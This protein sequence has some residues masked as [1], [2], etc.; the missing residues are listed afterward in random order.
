MIRLLGAAMIFGGCGSFGFAMAA[1]HRREERELVELLSAL[2]YMSCEL[3]FRQR[4]LPSL[5]RGA[6]QNRGEAVMAF[7]LSLAQ[8]LE[9]QAAP[10]VAGCMA[11]AL[12]ESD[13]PES[14]DRVLRNL[15]SSLGCFDLPGQLRGIE[16]ALKAGER[17]LHRVRDG[18]SQR[19][20]SYQT[21]GLCAGAALAIL[22]L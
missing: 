1:A 2:E 11:K 20:R 10:E 4:D 6:A 14:V 5:C 19:R 15:G 18:A 8:A 12:E 7:F 3:S 17:E 22:F 21:L 16:S 13:R 9:D